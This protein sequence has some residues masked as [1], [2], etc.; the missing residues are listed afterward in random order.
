MAGG[1]TVEKK[2]DAPLGEGVGEEPGMTGA[3]VPAPD[4]VRDYHGDALV[5]PRARA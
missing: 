1:C 4:A 3:A 5:C 2:T